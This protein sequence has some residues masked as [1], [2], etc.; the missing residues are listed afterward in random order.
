[1]GTNPAIGR[2]LRTDPLGILSVE[3]FVGARNLF[4]YSE[5]NPI[6]KIDPLG[7]DCFTKC[8]R[9]CI[10]ESYGSS[11]DTAIGLS[12]LGVVQI[13][14]SVYNGAVEAGAKEK[15]KNLKLAGAFTEGD[16]TKK[17]HAAE[18]AAKSAKSLSSWTKVLSVLSKA[19]SI[20]SA[21]AT[22]Y[23]VGASAYCTGKC[24]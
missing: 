7:L 23:V 10:K 22:G 1:M 16:I 18:K 20:V 14:Q 12:F 24:L 13:A 4:L 9:G 8:W 17:M 6:M 11:F 19:S 21:G 15:L 3:S 2:Y 5:A